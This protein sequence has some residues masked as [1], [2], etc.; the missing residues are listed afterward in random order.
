MCLLFSYLS[1]G[2]IEIGQFFIEVVELAIF[3][4]EMD[5]HLLK[6]KFQ[7]KVNI[8]EFH[9]LSGLFLAFLLLW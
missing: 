1:L 5:F 2:G 4:Y 3:D 6:A 8:I 7:E 9:V